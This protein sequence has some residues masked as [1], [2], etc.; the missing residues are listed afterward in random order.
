MTM[1]TRVAPH[2]IIPGIISPIFQR[3]P[4]RDTLAEVT[5]FGKRG[6]D[7]LYQPTVSRINT[8]T[9]I[10]Q[11]WRGD[12]DAVDYSLSQIS[13][14]Y[15]TIMA[16][17]EYDPNQESKFERLVTG[18]GLNDFLDK[19]CKQGIYQREHYACFF[20]FDANQGIA[21]TGQNG[22]LPA[23]SGG[24]T[25][26]QT[27]IVA[28]LLAFLALQA[29]TVMNNTYGMAKPVRVVSTVNMINYLKSTIVPLTS[30]QMPGA[31]V[32]SVAGSY[33]RIIGEWLG[34]GKID[35]IADNALIGKGTTSKDL[36]LFIAPGLSDQEVKSTEN[37][38]LVADE[39]PMNMRNTFMDMVDGLKE[40]QNPAINGIKS[41]LF[42]LQTTSGCLIRQEAVRA[43]SFT[44]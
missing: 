10:G 33:G 44:F 24:H 18:V 41:K 37:T 1:M 43:I 8:P 34:V 32:D 19:L 35:F 28:E 20:G 40:F 42:S 2:S 39:L 25:T 38:N 22:S 23:D 36:I 26:V 17:Q 16:R 7:V 13:F 30:Y 31:G 21:L 12:I 29:R 3:V 14:P 9:S 27:Y 15:Y 4:F 11:Q 6:D 5:R